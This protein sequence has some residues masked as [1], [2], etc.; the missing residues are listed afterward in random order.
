MPGFW[1]RVRSFFGSAGTSPSAAD[2]TVA[3]SS[4]GPAPKS[5]PRRKPRG[6]A[7]TSIHS[8]ILTDDDENA[9]VRGSR[10]YGEPG[11]IGW[12]QKMMRDPHVRQAHASRVDPLLGALWD[13]EPASEAPVDLEAAALARWV[14]FDRLSWTEFLRRVLLFHRDGF[15]LFEVTDDVVAIPRERFPL[16]PGR[17]RGIAITGF[18]HRP[19]WTLHGW[20][21]SKRDPTQL[22]GIEQ[23][24]QGSDV[25]DPGFTTIPAEMLLRFTQEQEGA[26]FA[27][28]ATNRS[29]FGPWKVKRMLM[30]LEAIMHER[31]GVATPMITLPEG[32]GPE[33]EEVD[34][35]YQI[36][37]E[38]RSHEK[39]SMVLPG[40]F[41]FEW[42]QGGQNTNIRETIEACNRDIAFNGASG[43]KLLGLSGGSGSYALAQSQQGSYELSL[44]GDASFVCDKINLGSD[45]WSPVERII[46]LNYGP[47]VGI[48]KLVV[49][50]MPTRDWSKVLPLVAQLKTAD[51]IR[52]D[53]AFEVFMR[54]VL[55]LPRR[56]TKTTRTTIPAPGAA[57]A[58]PPPMEPDPEE[59]LREAA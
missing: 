43:F 17:G 36:L 49:R 11:R 35:A 38:M 12:S 16:H 37:A 34:A 55:R 59:Q 9:E 45:G 13:F 26:N 40:G 5:P 3:T 4:S 32:V 41:K 56:D 6:G 18:H 57:A 28:F 24:L 7:G 33:D 31:M 51:I 50:N 19:A 15:S 8:G 22:D 30:V 1:T 27:G 46:R 2:P 29:A 52:A 25:E 14:F 47:D 23:Y 44:E 48:P 20:L 42:S 58:S 10:W 54:W 21:Q 39:G 53:D